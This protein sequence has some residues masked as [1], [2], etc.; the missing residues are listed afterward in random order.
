[1]GFPRTRST[2]AG[3]PNTTTAASMGIA[4]SRR[5]RRPRFTPASRAMSSP[6]CNAA[7]ASTEL[8]SA[9]AVPMTSASTLACC[10]SG[11]RSA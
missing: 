9:T 4:F 1:M 7:M 11:F 5:P 3:T 2:E 8:H 6:T 10:P